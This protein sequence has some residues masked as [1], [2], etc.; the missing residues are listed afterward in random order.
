VVPA[1]SRVEPWPEADVFQRP[2]VPRSR[3][4][5]RLK[6]G[7]AMTSNVKSWEPIFLHVLRLLPPGAR[8]FRCMSSI[9]RAGASKTRRLILLLAVGWVP[10]SLGPSGACLRLGTSRP[11]GLGTPARIAPHQGCVSAD[12]RRSSA[13]FSHAVV[14][15][16]GVTGTSLAMTPMQLTSSRAMATTTWLTF[17]PRAR[18]C[19]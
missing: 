13:A 6:R 10:P 11:D 3:F 7:V 18:N 19:R 8:S 5:P 2:L 12:T 16:D 9:R 17:F 1:P 15:T 4:Q 14:R